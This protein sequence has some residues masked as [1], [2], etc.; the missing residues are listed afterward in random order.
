MIARDSDTTIRNADRIKIQIG[1]KALGW[2]DLTYRA[3]LRGISAR[4]R[5]DCPV[6]SST[7]MTQI[8]GQ[9]AVQ[10]LTRLGVQFGPPKG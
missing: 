6:E 1:R 10:E 5:P 2:N 8:E 7:A 9:A 4:F 3:W